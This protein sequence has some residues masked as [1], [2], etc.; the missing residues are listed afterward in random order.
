LPRV[1]YWFENL[2]PSPEIKCVDLV[3]LILV[4][5][6]VFGYKRGNIA[7]G[8]W[9]VQNEVILKLYTLPGSNL[10]DVVDENEAN[11]GY[12]TLDDA[13]SIRL[14]DSTTSET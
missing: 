2:F 10:S 14:Y 4:L 5:R 9:K 6:R 1:L 13:K 3:F 12:S 7:G 8:W 11:R